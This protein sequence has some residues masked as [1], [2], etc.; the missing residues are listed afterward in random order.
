MN[1]LVYIFSPGLMGLCMGFSFVSL[2]EIIYYIGQFFAFH[3]GRK[4]KWISNEMIMIDNTWIVD[5][6]FHTVQGFICLMAVCNPVQYVST[7]CLICLDSRVIWPRFLADIYTFRVN[8]HWQWPA[9]ISPNVFTIRE[10]AIEFY[11]SFK[12]NIVM[13]HVPCVLCAADGAEACCPVK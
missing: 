1:F 7:T 13:C 4:N 9:T 10:Q 3:I 11:T 8:N 12:T 5:W 2:A 6:A